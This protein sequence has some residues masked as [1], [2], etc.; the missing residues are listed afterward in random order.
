MPKLY[1]RYGTMNSSK[2]ANLLMVAHNYESLGK[3]PILIKPQVDTRFDSDK[4]QCRAGFSRKANLI[5]T[6]ETDIYNL[7]IDNYS[8]RDIDVL[9]VDE[10]QFL[11]EKQIIDLRKL[12]GHFSVIAYGLRTNFKTRLFEGS[13]RLMELAD[14]IEEVKTICSI[15]C[16]KKAILNMKYTED[17]V[18]HDGDEI[19]IGAEDK[20]KA[21][22]WACYD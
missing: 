8:L 3:V 17:G 16:K 13:K 15:C 10:V 14:S 21:V 4:I 22:C 6:P 18:I 2:T 9:L 1:F 11:T 19:D 12:S 7:L 5:I 20:Y